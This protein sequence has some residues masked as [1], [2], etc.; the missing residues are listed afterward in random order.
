VI[1]LDTHAVVWLFALEERRFPRGARR[2]LDGEPLVVSP[3]V[4][5]DIQF[6]YEIG[7]VTQSGRIMITDL[8]DRIGLK[9][10]ETRLSDVVICATQLTWTRDPYDRLIVGQAMA[11]GVRLLTRDETLH[12][13]YTKAVW[14]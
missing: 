9:V 12:E 8:A 2:L 1:H 11:E 7:R 3:A 10:S 5:L 14:D 6:L 13:H 4:E